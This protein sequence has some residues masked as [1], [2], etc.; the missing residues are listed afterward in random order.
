[1]QGDGHTDKDE[2]NADAL[3]QQRSGTAE[4]I[5]MLCNEMTCSHESKKHGVYIDTKQLSRISL[6]TQQS[7][8]A[9]LCVNGRGGSRR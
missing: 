7:L 8:P 2:S 5:L 3:P 6:L 4:F 9:A 1:M